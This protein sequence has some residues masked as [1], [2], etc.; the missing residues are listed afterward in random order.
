M[1]NLL[2]D[3]LKKITPSKEEKEQIEKISKEIID[4][5]R[6]SAK[7]I[8]VEIVLGGSASRGT[9]LAGNHDLDIFVRFKS[10]EEIKNHFREMVLSNFPK[11]KSVYGTREYFRFKHKGFK[12]EIVPSVKY[13]SPSKATNSADISFFHI[14][15]LKN[16]IDKEMAKEVLLLKQFLKANDIYGAES[17]RGGFSGYVCEL[18]IIH[19]KTFKRLIE[20][21]ETAKPKVVIDIE[22]HYKNKDEILKKLD[23]N[24]I[25]GPL[26]IIDPQLPDRN[27]AA[28]VSYDSFSKL[29]FRAR[30]LIRTKDKRL[31]NIRG[32]K[33][34][35]LKERSKRRGTK[36]VYFKLKKSSEEFDI[37]KAKV[38]KKMKRLVSLLDNE[39]WDIYNYGVSD[40]K[41]M[42]VEF[43]SLKVSK[44]KRHFGPYVWVDSEHFDN[45]I[46]KWEGKSVGKPYVYKS[47]IVV[48]IVR[49]MKLK[50]EIREFMKEFL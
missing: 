38:L 26:I 40:D 34:A 30:Q 23:K 33:L 45:F 7:D 4:K 31:F 25:K 14:N 20:F 27:A 17:A 32:E 24:K 13:D 48:D 46:K 5:I 49:K 39:G 9:Y 8:D 1:D 42:Y 12:V 50:E 19:F 21:L 41:Y 6:K 36:L 43:E 47:R 44:T 35:L 10:E 28:C 22:K 29:V 16:R 3:V 11:A 15:Y 18:L 2:K 37:V